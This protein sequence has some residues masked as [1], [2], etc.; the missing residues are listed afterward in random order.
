VKDPYL[1][2]FGIFRLGLVQACLGAIIVLTT[3]VL[4]RVMHVELA[5]PAML[6]GALIAIHHTVQLMRP[7]MGYG[8]DLGGRHTPWIIGG[9]AVLASGGVLAALAT[10]LLSVSVVFGTALAA[11]SFLVIGVGVGATGTVLLVLMAKQVHPGRRAAAATTVWIMM[12]AGFIVSTAVAGNLLDPFS[13]R[14]LIQVIASIGA[15]AFVLTTLAMTGLERRTPAAATDAAGDDEA[16]VP[17]RTALGQIWGERQARLFTVFVFISML[18]YGAQDLVLEPFAGIV[19]GMTPGE[20]TLLSSTQNKGVLL[21]MLLIG[22]VCSGRLAGRFGSVR[23]W[24]IGGCVASALALA[25]LSFSGSVGPGWPIETTVFALGLANGIYAVGAITSMMQL[26]SDGRAKREGVRMGLWGAA[27]AI[28]MG[29]GMFLGTVAVDAV[30]ALAG[31]PAGAFQTVFAMQ[32]V[33]FLVAA[34]LA[35]RIAGSNAAPVQMP[36]PTDRGGAKPAFGE[37]GALVS[38]DHRVA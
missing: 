7:R 8:S 2:W 18:A 5:L 13:L 33:G 22:F 20:S 15:G 27:Q 38:T 23:A 37:S 31:S 29:L 16:R 32:A 12:I 28:A 30:R 21:G 9:M 3:S 11:L 19:F 4:N 14:R 1:G 10:A 6:P 24:T 35:M 34:M 36:A 25:T 26:A 17:F